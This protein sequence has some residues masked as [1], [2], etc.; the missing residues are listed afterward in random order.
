MGDLKRRGVMEAAERDVGAAQ[1][2]KKGETLASRLSFG[3]R[4][5]MKMFRRRNVLLYTI[6]LVLLYFS[7]L[8]VSKLS[9]ASPPDSD[10]SIRLRKAGKRVQEIIDTDP[11]LNSTSKVDFKSHE[12]T[13]SEILKATAGYQSCRYFG[14]KHRNLCCLNTNNQYTCFPTLIGIGAQKSGS[15]VLFARLMTNK[16]MKFGAKKEA[17]FFDFRDKWRRGLHHYLEMFPEFALSELSTH[18]TADFTP[19]YILPA[20]ACLRI[21]QVLPHARLV[22]ILRDPVKRAWSEVQ[23][24]L[25]YDVNIRDFV[26]RAVSTERFRKCAERLADSRTFLSDFRLNSFDSVD[27]CVPKELRYQQLYRQFTIRVRALARDNE[28][29]ANCTK[30]ARESDHPDEVWLQCIVR[31]SREMITLEDEEDDI[32]QDL[33]REKRELEICQQQKA[34][35]C[36]GQARKPADISRDNLYRGLYAFQLSECFRWFPRE[37]VLVLDNDDLKSKPVETMRQVLRHIGLDENA[38]FD[39][40]DSNAWAAFRE[41]YPHFESITGWQHDAPVSEM[42]PKVRRFLE[43]YYE[44]PNQEIEDLLGRKFGW[45]KTPEGGR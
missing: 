20:Q 3:K 10:V 5:P 34:N 2:E 19:S 12:K 15:T 37:Q 6:G 4:I 17:H 38:A 22:M 35:R 26:R 16:N 21:R 43:N 11:W 13:M 41:Q 9:V 18:L 29:L 32:V 27:T 36:F 24:K 7:V 23:M 1:T 25:R 28:R 30:N 45:M 8:S 33:E 44:G 39:L 40:N 42:P 14:R 31:P